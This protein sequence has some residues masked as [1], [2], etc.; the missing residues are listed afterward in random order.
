MDNTLKIQN[1]I[2]QNAEEVSSYLT[3]L[4][5][6]EKSMKQ[7]E[8]RVRGGAI[9]QSPPLSSLTSSSSSSMKGL[10]SSNVNK[11]INDNLPVRGA[12]T[13]NI[14]TGNSNADSSTSSSISKSAASHTYDIGYKKWEN[15]NENEEISHVQNNDNNETLPENENNASPFIEEESKLTP[16]SVIQRISPHILTTKTSYAPVPRAK[17]VANSKDAETMERERG[18]EE[19]VKG[20][21]AA[22]VKCYT[23]CLGL[24]V[25]NVTAFSNRAMTYLKLKEYNRA[26]TDCSCALSVDDKHVKSL[27]RRA[28]ARNA[29]GKHRAALLDLLKLADIDSSTNKQQVVRV[30]ILRT[31]ELLRSAVNRAP[32]IALQVEYLNPNDLDQSDLDSHLHLQEGPDLQ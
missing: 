19:F 30:E 5:K 2:R 13:V 15:F 11:S 4:S 14:T 31:R 16:S 18:N 26:E 12:G 21:F 29:L 22:A 23:K 3:D 28:T 7:K 9:S 8:A 1:Q 6:W 32:L 27:L 20:N 24:K 10:N 25:G 17:G